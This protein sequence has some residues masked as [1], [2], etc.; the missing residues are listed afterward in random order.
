[1]NLQH[2]PRRNTKPH[3]PVC[4]KD[5]LQQVEQVCRRLGVETSAAL[6]GGHTWVVP[7]MSWYHADWD[8]QPDIPGAMQIH[9]V[10]VWVGFLCFGGA[11]ERVTVKQTNKKVKTH[12]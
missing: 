10:G 2:T 4:T 3:P 11:C 6:I 5:K 8:T 9:K 1:M 7:L 12:K